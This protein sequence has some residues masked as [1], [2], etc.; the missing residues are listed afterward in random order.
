MTPDYER[1]VKPHLALAPNPS[2]MYFITIP[3]PPW[4]K[5]RPRFGTKHGYTDP[6]DR[7]AEMRTANAFRDVVDQP[8]TGNVALTCIFYRHNRQRVDA[9]NLLKHV[10]DSGNNVLWIDDAQITSVTG[11]V[12]LDPDSPRTIVMIGDHTSSLTRGTDWWT[13]C[14]TCGNRIL[15]G[16]WSGRTP[17][18]CSNTCSKARFGG[19]D[20]SI[21][22]ACQGCGHPFIRKTSTQ[23]NCSNACIPRLGRPKSP[24]RQESHCVDCGGLLSKPGYQR[25][26]ACWITARAN[27]IA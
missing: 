3:G 26:R 20:L 12:E 13:T 9:D 2:Q 21:P 16:G 27:A 14:A 4:S 17:K 23:K 24:D 5:S 10:C 6:K 8:F 15:L 19:I 11:I 7:V 18:Y 1:I 22:V 25:C